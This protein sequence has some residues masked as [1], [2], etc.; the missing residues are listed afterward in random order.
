M[1]DM[2]DQLKTFLH[3]K[4][5]LTDEGYKKDVDVEFHRGYLEE[6]QIPSDK[7]EVQV[8]HSSGSQELLHAGVELKGEATLTVLVSV[9]AAQDTIADV[10]AA[11]DSKVKIWDEIER[12]LLKE[13]PLPS[14]WEYSWVSS[15][16]NRDVPG[17]TPL[18]SELLY[19]KVVYVKI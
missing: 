13:T 12:I 7:K 14:G 3:E 18:I 16:E 9:R 6:E 1:V 11:K 15:Y 5:S 2:E 10:E 19:V 4:W 8:G 17:P